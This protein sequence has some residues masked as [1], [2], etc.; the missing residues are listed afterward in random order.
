MERRKFVVGL[1]AL[2]AGSSAAMGT[3]AF[4]AFEADRDADIAVTNDAEAYVALEPGDDWGERVDAGDYHDGAYAELNGDGVLEITIDEL[5][6]EAKTEFRNVFRIRNNSGVDDND[7]YEGDLQSNIQFEVSG[8]N[9]S[10]LTV[11]AREDQR[12]SQTIE[13]DG[14]LL[15]GDADQI[16]R[17]LDD[18][19]GNIGTWKYGREDQIDLIVDTSGLE[20]GDTVAD[21]LT[22]TAAEPE[23]ADSP[24]FGDD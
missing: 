16:K 5:N 13:D 20:D 9:A 1:G 4:S 15:D 19:G 17:V 6:P 22:I 2:A 21:T 8:G 7:A 23:S 12:D 10:A 11:V 24:N 14:I 3:G 18:G